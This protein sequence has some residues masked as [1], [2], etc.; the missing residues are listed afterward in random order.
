MIYWKGQPLTDLKS[1]TLEERE[2]VGGRVRARYY[3]NEWAGL[4]DLMYLKQM[5]E[6]M[7]ETIGK[8]LPG[9]AP[10][11]EA[12]MRQF[13]T[14]ATR[15]IDTDKLDYEGFL[16]PLV[17]EAYAIYMSSMRVQADGSVRDSDNWQKGIPMDVYMKSMWRHFFEVWRWHRGVMVGCF[18]SLICGL[19]FNVMGYYHE[20]LKANPDALDYWETA[21]PVIR[22]VELEKRRAKS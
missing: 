14:G 2:H 12:I 16:S 10:L 18:H 9:P 17:L 5:E 21:A 8:T 15:D 6:D 1:L 3:A 13:D 4:K 11:P 20:W 22:E 7:E 19:L